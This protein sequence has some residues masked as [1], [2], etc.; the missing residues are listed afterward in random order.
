[1]NDSDDELLS[2]VVDGIDDD[3]DWNDTGWAQPPPSSSCKTILSPKPCKQ[4][5]DTLKTIDVPTIGLQNVDGR[6]SLQKQPDIA[7]KTTES[8]DVQ[9]RALKESIAD[10]GMAKISEIKVR[11]NRCKMNFSR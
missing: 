8:C 5:A 11:E 6:L 10:S 9:L 1:M 2:S 7:G 4:R 3:E